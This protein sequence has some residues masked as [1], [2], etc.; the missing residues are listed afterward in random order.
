MW[1]RIIDRFTAI[2]TNLMQ[3]NYEL[4][5]EIRELKKLINRRDDTNGGHTNEPLE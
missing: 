4:N 5:K 2:I 3:E 1:E